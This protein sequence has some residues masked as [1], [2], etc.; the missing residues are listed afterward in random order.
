MWV[1]CSLNIYYFFEIFILIKNLLGVINW[2]F[3]VKIV[4]VYIIVKIQNLKCNL[5]FFVIFF[6]YS[7]DNCIIYKLKDNLKNKTTYFFEINI[8]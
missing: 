8:F 1:K 5:T 6:L 2:C 3:Y 4:I 7:I